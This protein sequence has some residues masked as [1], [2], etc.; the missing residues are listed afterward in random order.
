MNARRTAVSVLALSPLLAVPAVAQT[1][2]A[3]PRIQTD[4]DCYADVGGDDR[5]PVILSGNQFQPNADYQINLD[6][7]PLPGGTGRTDALGAIGPGEVRTPSLASLG[8]RQRRWTLRV[9]SGAQ[10]ATT[11]F[12]TSDVFAG[13]SPSRGRPSTLKVRFTA[14]GFNLEQRAKAP[15]VY[16]HYVRPNGRRKA[17]VRLG[18]ATGACGNLARTKLRRLFPF[19]AE[20]GLWRLQFD[21]SPTYRKGTSKTTFTYYTVGVR[22]RTVTG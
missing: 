11:S 13:F 12:F 18:T 15:S 14:T 17:T 7:Q 9:D 21:T 6:G 1:P 3:T 20:K 10:S 22:I 19:E 8:E 2:A 4:L 16:L 5:R